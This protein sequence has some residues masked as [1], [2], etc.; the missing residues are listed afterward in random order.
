[1]LTRQ[2]MCAITLL[3]A[4]IGPLCT[5]Y[6]LESVTDTNSRASNGA[7]LRHQAQIRSAQMNEVSTLQAQADALLECTAKGRLYAPGDAAAD[8]HG[9]I[10]IQVTIEQ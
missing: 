4:S 8:A 1:M 3:A 10:D 2:L 5:A 9:C 7:L 6:A